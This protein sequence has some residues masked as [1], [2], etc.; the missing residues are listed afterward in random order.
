MK[1]NEI[2]D[3]DDDHANALQQTGFWGRAGTG[4]I[5]LSQDTGLIGIAHRSSQVE[6]PNTW[7]TVGG[8]IDQGHDPA[9][10]AI[11]EAFEELHYRKRPLDYLRH[12]DQFQSGTFRYTTYLYVVERQFNAVLN[13]ES[14]DFQWFQ[15]GKWPSP[16]HF[17]LIATLSKP[18]C[19]AVI[20]EE[21][22]KY[23][24]SA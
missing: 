22:R 5:F 14:Q 24:G 1:V 16:L 3:P 6:Q 13:W 12:L 19:L 15:F 8:A 4:S 11:K 17:G 20:E 21:V 2:F 23:I 9:T 7:G 18:D 10:T